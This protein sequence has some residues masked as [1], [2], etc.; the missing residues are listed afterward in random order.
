MI[1]ILRMNRRDRKLIFI[2][3][4]GR[5]GTHLMG[6]VISTHP[7]ITGRIEEPDT[8]KLI[9]EI[10][11][12]QDFEK[13]WSI[14]KLKMLL[15]CRIRRIKWKSSNIVLEKSHP[16]L[17]IAESLLS[18]FKNDVLFICMVRGLEATVSSMLHHKGVLSW[19]N[20]LPQNKPNRFLGID[21]TNME[22]FHKLSLEEK[23][24]LRWL[25]HKREIY[26]LKEKYPDRVEIVSYE[27]LI[28]NPKI[29]M[30]V[31]AKFIGI[32]NEFNIEQIEFSSLYKWKSKL[33]YSQRKRMQNILRND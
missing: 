28:K 12:T 32:A 8:F 10:A 15:W 27:E 4:T 11:T 25:S 20:R 24:T 18:W 2:A 33:S 26:R 14:A 9:T 16:S 21:K 6:Q 19:Y 17:W 1:F 13:F 29:Q 7:K 30:N 23:C 3:G 22:T 31:I 5:S